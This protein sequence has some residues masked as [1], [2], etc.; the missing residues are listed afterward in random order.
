MVEAFKVTGGK[1][2]EGV[3]VVEGAKMPLFQ[4]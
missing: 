2:I 3:L 4:L 1:E